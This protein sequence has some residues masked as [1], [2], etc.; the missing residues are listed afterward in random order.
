[1]TDDRRT[2]RGRTVVPLDR[3]SPRI[4]CHSIARYSIQLYKWYIYKSRDQEIVTSIGRE[5]HGTS[6]VGAVLGSSLD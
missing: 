4:F 1:M 3:A 5:R 2:G 6:E